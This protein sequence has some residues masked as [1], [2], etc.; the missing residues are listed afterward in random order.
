MSERKGL[1]TDVQEDFLAELLDKKIPF[2]NPVLELADKLVFKTVIS[3]VDNNVLEKIPV[4]WQNP[5][6]PIIDAA[7]EEDWDEAGYL[8]AKL[9]N[10]KLDIPGIDE[11]SEQLIFNAIVSLILGLIMDRISQN[12][13]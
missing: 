11:L 9:A 2:G 10:Q 12:S 1:F 8:I 7:I 4:G 6:E 13:N 5:L 3:V